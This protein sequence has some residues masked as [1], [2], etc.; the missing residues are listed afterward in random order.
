MPTVLSNK[1]IEDPERV[2]TI[3]AAL[4]L[5]G[6]AQY[7]SYSVGFAQS[8]SP[9]AINFGPCGTKTVLPSPTMK[10]ILLCTL[11]LFAI[12][13]TPAQTPATPADLHRM[14]DDYYRWRN[15]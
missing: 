15:Q 6:S 13:N 4:T 7:D 12:V 5:S 3:Y 9:T 11:I 1:H 8:R 14:A 2:K 10:P